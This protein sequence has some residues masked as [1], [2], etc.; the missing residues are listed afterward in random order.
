[1]LYFVGPS[2]LTCFIILRG[3]V[4]V[5]VSLFLYVPFQTFVSVVQPKN[6]RVF[7]RSNCD[8]DMLFGFFKR[9]F[10]WVL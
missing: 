3:H 4:R 7:Q 5:V 6:K 1:M 10:L 9:L 2:L 8:E